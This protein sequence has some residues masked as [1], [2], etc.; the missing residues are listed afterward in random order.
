MDYQEQLKVMSKQ[1]YALQKQ[2]VNVQRLIVTGNGNRGS[3][4][5]REP[6]IVGVKDI[7]SAQLFHAYRKGLNMAQL[8]QLADGKYTADQIYK[9]L[10]KMG[11]Q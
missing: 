3:G 11:V 6:V 4:V 8:V 1:L 10:Q 7:T 9:K 2:L 5:V